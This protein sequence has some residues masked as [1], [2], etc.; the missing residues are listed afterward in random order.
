MFTE[1]S[2]FNLAVMTL[3]D[4]FYLCLDGTSCIRAFLALDSYDL[5][6]S[7]DNWYRQNDVLRNTSEQKFCKKRIWTFDFEA[8]LLS[9]LK[10][11]RPR[12]WMIFFVQ[13]LSKGGDTGSNFLLLIKFTRV[14]KRFKFSRMTF[15][16]FSTKSSKSDRYSCSIKV[17][18]L[19]FEL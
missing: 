3:L 8:S 11:K 9:C 15:D 6:T 10:K 2:D 5:N 12:H 19:H 16:F 4:C 14:R 1:F 13:F 7:P 18:M 17:S